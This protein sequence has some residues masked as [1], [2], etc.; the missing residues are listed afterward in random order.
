MSK[1]Q[2]NDFEI[3]YNYVRKRYSFLAEQCPESLWELSTAFLSGKGAAIELSRGMGFYFLEL[4]LKN[5]PSNTFLLR[6]EMS[7][8]NSINKNED[9]L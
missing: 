7:P 9:R 8:K 3:G 1:Q 6:Q 5:L 2:I 4:G